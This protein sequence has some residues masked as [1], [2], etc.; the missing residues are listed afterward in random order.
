MT[1]LD[2]GFDRFGV[3]VLD[4]ALDLTVRR[5]LVGVFF[6]LSEDRFD[7]PMSRPLTQC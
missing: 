7:P 2:D 1:R 6:C 4:L 5:L 3:V